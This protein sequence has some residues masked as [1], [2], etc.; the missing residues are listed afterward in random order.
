WRR[1]RIILPRQASR[2]KEWARLTRLRV[3]SSHSPGAGVSTAG[4][5]AFSPSSSF[6]MGGLQNDRIKGYL[7]GRERH[8]GR[9]LHNGWHPRWFRQ[10]QGLGGQGPIQLSPATA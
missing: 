8:H 4:Q 9:Y 6:V 7:P 3:K 1:K 10:A 5:R 2:A